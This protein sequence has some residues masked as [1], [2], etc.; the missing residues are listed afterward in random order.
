M[1]GKPGAGK[2]TLSARLVEKYDILSLSTGDLLRQHIA[3]K[4]EVGREA[5]EIVAQGGLLPDDMVLRVVTTH[6]DKLHNKH[7]ILDGFPRTLRQG[8]LLDNHLKNQNM[9]LSL[10]VNIDVPDSI[11]LSRISDR[12]VHLPSGRVYNMSYNRPK[13]DGLDDKTGEPLSKR[14]DDNPETFA[15][16]LAKFYASTSPLLS[17]FDLAQDLSPTGEPKLVTLTGSTSDEIWPKLDAHVRG[18]FPGLRERAEVRGM[19]SR[20][21]SPADVQDQLGLLAKENGKA[22]MEAWAAASRWSA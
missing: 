6:L 16:R 20:A 22:M 15:R 14:P 10:V 12:W 4:T 8:E 17:Y 19:R 21:P 7:W 13:V 11:I 2:G 9:P 3:E 5:E 1:F 18:A